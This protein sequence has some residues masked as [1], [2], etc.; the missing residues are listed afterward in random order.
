VLLQ[1][2]AEKLATAE[3]VSKKI[4]KE[5]TRYEHELEGAKAKKRMQ[6]EVHQQILQEQKQREAF[7][8]QQERLAAEDLARRE[9]AAEELKR[10][11]IMKLTTS[12]SQF[13]KLQLQQEKFYK[14]FF[15]SSPFLDKSTGVESSDSSTGSKSAEP[16]AKH[17][18]E[19][20]LVEDEE[21]V[22]FHKQVGKK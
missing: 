13:E 15:A 6:E 18:P 11:E 17:R 19:L 20:E 21:F 9:L 8:E 4:E 7:K 14:Q 12:T 3:N 2:E 5:D 10:E 22:M 1:K 16:A